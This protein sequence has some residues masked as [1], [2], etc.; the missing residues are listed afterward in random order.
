[1]ENNFKLSPKF[2][3]IGGLPYN[4]YSLWV[5]LYSSGMNQFEV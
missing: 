4:Y 3:F 2:D 1:M 5:L